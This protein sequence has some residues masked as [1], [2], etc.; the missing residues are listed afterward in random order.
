MLL[1]QP[2]PARIISVMSL[3]KDDLKAIK[4]IVDTSVNTAVDALALQTAQGFAEVH[5][6][7]DTVEKRLDKKVDDV[8]LRLGRR[9]D[10]VEERLS[11][12]IQEVDDKLSVKD[13]KLE[14]T[15]QRVDELE[16]AVSRL[17]PKAA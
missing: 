13:L 14:N 1:K 3:T 5:G 2:Q 7:I 10:G 16:S 15:V 9:I 4:G 8:E 17:K 12:K 6:K 11:A